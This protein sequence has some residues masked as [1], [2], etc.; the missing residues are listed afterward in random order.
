MSAMLTWIPKF[1]IVLA[2]YRIVSIPH[3]CLIYAAA[4]CMLKS[5]AKNCKLV[6]LT[7]FLSAMVIFFKYLHSYRTINSVIP[8]VKK[9]RVTVMLTV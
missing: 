7:M 4:A 6:S 9:K 8:I 1:V 5:H 3:V 2:V